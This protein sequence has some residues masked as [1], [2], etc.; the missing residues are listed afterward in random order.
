MIAIYIY[1][2]NDHLLTFSNLYLPI[3]VIGYII[4]SVFIWKGTKYNQFFSICNITVFSLLGLLNFL[5]S[6]YGITKQVLE[7][8][9]SEE[10]TTKMFRTITAQLGLYRI[11]LESKGATKNVEPQ[12]KT[13]WVHQ[14]SFRYH[15]ART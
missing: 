2:M 1:K 10:H 3:N 7:F 13:T 14:G 11:Y 9:A 6:G 5:V 8:N 15:C 12:F 4:W